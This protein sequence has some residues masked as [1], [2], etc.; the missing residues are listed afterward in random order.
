MLFVYF[1]WH[2][3]SKISQGRMGDFPHFYYAALALRTGTDIHLSWRQ[4]YLYP[5]LWAFLIRPLTAI[6]VMSAA[7]VQVLLNCSA[8]IVAAVLC[9]REV[10]RRLLGRVSAAQALLVALLCVFVV[11]N[12]F[13]AEIEMGQTNT[14]VL[15]A[16]VLSLSLLDR[17]PWLSGLAL[18]FA[19]NIKFQTG[20]FLPYLLFRRRWMAA[21]SL[22][23]GIV[24]WSLLPMTATGWTTGVHNLAVAYLGML[25][26]FGL[27]TAMHVTAKNPM[28]APFSLS[29]TSAMARIVGPGRE[30]TALML[31]S[32]VL[33]LWLLA[34]FAAY[35][36][37]GIPFIHWPC[38]R[39]QH[40]EK[41]R[42]ATALEW[43]GII[44]LSLAFSP[45]TNSRHLILLTLP[46]AAAGTLILRAPRERW[47]AAAA[48]AILACGLL[49][50]PGMPGARESLG[51]WRGIGGQSWSILGS[52]WL[53]YFAGLRYVSRCGTKACPG[54][55]A[56]VAPDR[57][58]RYARYA[59]G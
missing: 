26:L 1:G 33:A 37:A 45:Q 36:R 16:T 9:S 48:L 8:A 52:C 13:R 57:P 18:G 47:L 24:F 11:N 14:W 29:I 53:V 50:P 31:S 10:G 35:R 38:A 58:D 39:S 5:P 12:A 55:D 4:G 23:A 3:I 34:V 27:H 54:G 28:G 22:C 51:W 17:H 25:D 59:E 49:L 46:V 6:D 56:P 2:A 20:A 30:G 43:A 40:A 15:L 19:F 44:S 32:G 21:L 42:A 7:K 41:W